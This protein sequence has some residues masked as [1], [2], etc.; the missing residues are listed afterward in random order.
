M[1]E[2]E[3]VS[4]FEE[5]MDQVLQRV[6]DHDAARIAQGLEGLSILDQATKVVEPIWKGSELMAQEGFGMAWKV[7][8][9]LRRCNFTGSIFKDIYVGENRWHTGLN[10]PKNLDL[11]SNN[12]EMNNFL[13]GGESIKSV[14]FVSRVG[15]DGVEDQMMLDVDYGTLRISYIFTEQAFYRRDSRKLTTLDDLSDAGR[16]L[17]GIVSITEIFLASQSKSF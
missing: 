5:T 9:S 7:L 17:E 11:T 2:F 4:P 10:K 3:G 1:R 6:L 12:E 15:I 8:E 13:I 16:V 14:L